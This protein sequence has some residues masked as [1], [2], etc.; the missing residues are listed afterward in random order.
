[1]TG[2]MTVFAVILPIAIIA[3][4]VFSIASPNTTTDGIQRSTVK[5]EKL[6]NVVS[7]DVVKY[8]DATRAGDWFFGNPRDLTNGATAA[9]NATGVKFGIYVTEGVAFDEL[10]ALG[11]EVY[12]EWFGTSEG[13][14]LIVLSDTGYGDFDAYD[15]IGYQARTVFDNEAMDIFF[16]Y[17]AKYWDLPNQYTEYQMFGRTLEETA[18]RI[19]SITPTF[20]TTIAPFLGA[21]AVILVVVIGLIIFLKVKTKR[22]EAAADLARADAELLSTPMPGDGTVPPTG[23]ES[24]QPPQPPQPPGPYEGSG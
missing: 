24:Q 10:E 20:G 4:I 21:A 19:M 5:R 17:F 22:D 3:A 15:I 6:T 9:Y 18:T 16:A 2:C 14:L 11:N 13:H 1:M 8:E 23:W 7:G 12:D